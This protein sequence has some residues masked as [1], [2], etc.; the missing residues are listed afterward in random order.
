MTAHRSRAFVAL[1]L[2]L[3]AAALL[4]V[5]VY[6]RAVAR[7]NEAAHAAAQVEDLIFRELTIEARSLGAAIADAESADILRARARYEA[8]LFGRALADGMAYLDPVVEARLL[9]LLDV[10]LAGSRP[11]SAGLLARASALGLLAN[12]PVIRRRLINKRTLLEG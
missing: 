10:E 9:E 1:R 11:T 7:R 5:L 3:C 6:G 2:G 12:D 8:G 4:T